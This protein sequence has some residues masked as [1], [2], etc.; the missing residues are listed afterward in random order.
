MG[1]EPEYGIAA[2]RGK[3]GSAGNRLENETA[4]PIGTA[5]S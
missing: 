4:A 5:A 3:G 2:A 1:A